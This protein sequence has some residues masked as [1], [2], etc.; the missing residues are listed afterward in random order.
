MP[1]TTYTSGEVLTASSLNANF[2][3]AAGAGGLQ[4]ITAQ[5]IGSA[6]GSVTVSNCFSATYDAY[7]IIVSG[8]AGTVTN[9]NFTMTL[10]ASVTGYNYSFIYNSYNATTASEGATNAAAWIDLG[11][12][13]T[14]S[15]SLNMD[16]N[17]PFLAKNTTFSSSLARP[18][19]AGTTNGIHTV[20]TSYSGFTLNVTS[21]T[22]TGGTIRVY[23]YQNS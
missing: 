21:G 23:G 12:V 5:T 10:G 14:T 15:L 22:I 13:D 3:F 2:S 7:K 11:G 8:G 17:G 1:L 4:L 16:V 20:A 9:N 6:V 18:N 19:I